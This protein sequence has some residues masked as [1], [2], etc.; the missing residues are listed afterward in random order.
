MRLKLVHELELHPLPLRAARSR[1]LVNGDHRKLAKVG[2]QVAPLDVEL[3]NAESFDRAV[4]L[5]P[6]IEADAAVAFFLGVV[7][8]AAKAGGREHFSSHVRRL[9]LEF[10]HAENIG[11]LPR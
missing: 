7:K 2:A 5:A 1:R 6:A 9:C 11:L 10:L 4:R 3:A 8:I